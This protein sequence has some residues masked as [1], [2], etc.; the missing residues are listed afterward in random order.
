MRFH[1][2]T[3]NRQKFEYMRKPGCGERKVKSDFAFWIKFHGKQFFFFWS[4]RELC[5]AIFLFVTIFLWE[6]RFGKDFCDKRFDAIVLGQIFCVFVCQSL[7]LWQNLTTETFWEI[8]M[9]EECCDKL[10][11]MLIWNMI[12]DGMYINSARTKRLH[13]KSLLHVSYYP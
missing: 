6:I 2:S 13:N 7:F 10:C 9:V 1:F 5:F 11:D 4:G 3:L 8:F 12:Y